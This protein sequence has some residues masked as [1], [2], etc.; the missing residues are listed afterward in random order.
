MKK[1]RQQKNQAGKNCGGHLIQFCP[2]GRVQGCDVPQRWAP[3][4]D[5]GILWLSQC[6]PS[7]GN[8]GRQ[9]YLECRVTMILCRLGNVVSFCWITKR[10]PHRLARLKITQHV[11]YVHWLDC[12]PTC[13]FAWLPLCKTWTAQHGE[14]VSWH[15][16]PCHFYLL[17][18][19]V[20]FVGIHNKWQKCIPSS[21][22]ESLRYLKTDITTLDL[23]FLW[24]AI[25]A[26]SVNLCI[27]APLNLIML[28]IVIMVQVTASSEPPGMPH[29]QVI[30]T[31]WLALGRIVKKGVYCHF[32]LFSP[33][34]I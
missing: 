3:S 14:F 21:V 25:P 6:V 15:L 1:L 8:T 7:M 29:H 16:P 11:G 17:E 20:S 33:P 31:S 18:K 10:C 26:P 19:M 5:L 34:Y 4:L 30:F 24:H 2:R 12:K 22:E 32:P 23:A 27:K 9:S 28:I 13:F